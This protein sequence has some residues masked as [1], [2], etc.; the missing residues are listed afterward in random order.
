MSA[1]VPTKLPEMHLA[2]VG[3]AGAQSRLMLSLPKSCRGLVIT[4]VRAGTT[5]IRLSYCHNSG[6]GG[7]IRR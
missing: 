1:L 7:A 2:L 6:S 5:F 3:G 4:S